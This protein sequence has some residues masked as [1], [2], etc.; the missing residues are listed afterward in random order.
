MCISKYIIEINS[1][2]IRIDKL[3]LNPVLFCEYDINY[4][5]LI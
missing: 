2:K 5:A 1:N 4:I 3:I